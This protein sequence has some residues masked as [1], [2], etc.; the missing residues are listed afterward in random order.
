LVKSLGSTQGLPMILRCLRMGEVSG[1]AGVVV[2]C[3]NI[4][5]NT[6]GEGSS[7]ERS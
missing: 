1:I 6:E 3:V 7:L 4:S 2:K 5:K